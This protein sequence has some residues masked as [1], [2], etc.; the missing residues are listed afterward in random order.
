MSHLSTGIFS[1][2]ILSNTGRLRVDPDKKFC[3]DEILKSTQIYLLILNKNSF[4][5]IMLTIKELF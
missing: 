1:L 3:K 4:Y 5:L 2:S